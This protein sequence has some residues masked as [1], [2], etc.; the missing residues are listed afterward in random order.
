MPR[1][2]PQ[3]ETHVRPLPQLGGV[4][5]LRQRIGG[6]DGRRVQPQRWQ[7]RAS[8]DV[9]S[10]E[11]AAA[12]TQLQEEAEAEL[13]LGRRRGGE[14]RGRGRRNRYAT[15]CLSNSPPSVGLQSNRKKS[16]ETSTISDNR[17]IFLWSCDRKSHDQTVTVC[18]SVN[19]RNMEGRHIGILPI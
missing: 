7:R 8:R 18:D 4:R 19:K 3:S 10:Q 16:W 14:R 11:R 2:T 17:P 12:P 6:R 13:V 9:P 1:R 15:I 5:R